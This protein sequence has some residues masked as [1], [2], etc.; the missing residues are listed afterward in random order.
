MGHFDGSRIY[1]DG[2]GLVETKV[3]CDDDWSNEVVTLRFW[4]PAITARFSSPL[5]DPINLAISG[6]SHWRRTSERVAR[7]LKAIGSVS[8]RRKEIEQ[9]LEVVRA[10]GGH[11]RVIFEGIGDKHYGAVVTISGTVGST[12]DLAALAADYQA[13][14]AAAPALAA[15]VVSELERLSPLFFGDFDFE[16]VEVEFIPGSGNKR[17][18]GSLARCGLL[19]GYPVATTAALILGD[20]DLPGGHTRY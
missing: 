17:R 19:L 1:R 13:Y 15:E 16:D 8:G 4:H 20:H 18:P 10:S 9:A 2:P 3:V 12:F 7:R 5:V 11:G 6:D 14:L